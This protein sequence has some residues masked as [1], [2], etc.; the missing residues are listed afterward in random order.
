MKVFIL[1][2]STLFALGQ[3]T[4]LVLFSVLGQLTRPFSHK[5]RYAFMSKWA[6]F[7]LAWLR[8]TCGI[9]AK[10]QGLEQIDPKKAG[11]IL[12]RH[13]SAWETLY[14]QTIFPRQAYVLKQ[15][16]LR[17]PFFGWG[18]SLLHPI[19]ID[20]AGGRAALKQLLTE[21]QERLANGNW[22]VIFP[23]GTRMPPNELGKINV[24]GAML[25]K[26]SGVPV[27]LVSHNAGRLWPK[28]SFLKH[29][30]IIDVQ[31][32]RVDNLEALSLSELNQLTADWFSANFESPTPPSGGSNA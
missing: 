4:T 12:A 6:Y 19:A 29:P 9:R 24:G 23:E 14:L 32:Q 10:P 27:Y 31:V 26:Q 25:A 3:I 28:N 2:R 11:L 1:L 16:L 18:M 13:E 7:C 5:V 8:V 22:V 21:G 15:E 30:G 20:R 17:I